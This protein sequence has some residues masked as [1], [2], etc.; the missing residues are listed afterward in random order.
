MKNILTIFFMVFSFLSNA[1]PDFNAR[2]VVEGVQCYRDAAFPGRAYYVPHKLSVAKDRDGKPDFIFIQTRYTG[3]RTYGDEGAERFHSIIKFRIIME[4]YSPELL[5]KVKSK[6]WNNI[7]KA[8]LLPVPICSIET[9]LGFPSLAAGSP[10]SD[11]I[12]FSNGSFTSDTDKGKSISGAYWTER[13]FSVFLDENSSKI[14]WDAFINNQTIISFSYAFFARGVINPSADITSGLDEA[15]RILVKM[16][17]ELKDT[18]SQENYCVLADAFSFEIDAKKWPGLMKKIDINEE[19]PPGY[20]VL[21]VRCYDFAN[22]FR[23]DLYAKNVEFKA[24]GVGKGDVIV[25]IRFDQKNPDLYVN[26]IHFG[27]AVRLDKPLY[28]RVTEISENI[29]PEKTDWLLLDT[30]HSMIDITS[31]K[32][33]INKVKEEL[34]IK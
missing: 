10:G 20:P 21:Q 7:S 26:N 33:K 19:I 30:W 4:R 25:R 29:E 27:Y 12:T 17:E 1:Q 24:T 32:D 14:I 31:S 6:L 5:E 11:T 8:E 28:Y 13:V 22:D 34:E 18:I 3:T 9:L 2:I 15:S 16:F 23:P